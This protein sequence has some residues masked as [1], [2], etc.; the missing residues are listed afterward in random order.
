MLLLLPPLILPDSARV[1]ASPVTWYYPTVPV[2][3]PLLHVTSDTTQQC[4]CCC[5]FCMSHLILPNSLRVAASP[6]CHI[7]YYPTVYVLLP[8]LHVTSDTTQQCTCCCLSCMS[9]LILP[10]SVR[11]AAS[12]VTWYYPTVPVLLP[13]LHVTCW[14]YPTV[15]VLL[16]LLHVTSDTTQQSTCCCLSCMSHLILPNSVHVAASSACHIWYNSVRV[17][18]SPA[19]HIWYYPT[20]YVLLPLLHVT[21]DTTQQCTCCCLSCHIW[22][23]PTVYTCCCLTCQRFGNAVQMLFR[24]KW[25]LDDTFALYKCMFD[26]VNRTMSRETKP[27]FCCT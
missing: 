19:C 24:G 2:L 14:Y 6:A 26:N 7:W 12:P 13:L 8:L 3:L 20:V 21:S 23:Y 18:A 9:H 10:N 1:A 11:F 16:P 17:A 27:V 15:Y 5:L 4:T 25:N 22:Y